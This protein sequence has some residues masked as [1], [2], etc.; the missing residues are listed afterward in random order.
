MFNLPQLTG[1]MHNTFIQQMSQ[2]YE[3]EISLPQKPWKC[4]W[5]QLLFKRKLIT[6][7]LLTAILFVTLPFFFRY[8]EN[9]EG[10]TINDFVLQ[11]VKPHNV[12]IPVFIAIWSMTAL[13]IARSL[14]KPELFLVCI[15]SFLVVTVLRLLAIFLVPLNAPE[16][17]IP[18]VDPLSNVFYGKHFVTKDLFFSG[19]TAS[20][21]LIFLCLD[22]RQD[23]IAALVA[24]LV[25]GICVLV[26]HVHYTFDVIAAPVFTYL[27]Y[28]IG[29][30]LAAPSAI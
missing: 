26:Q 24:T 15:Y 29:K 28:R 9:R 6:A 2:P 27:A 17:L 20:Q 7:L 18:L 3:L 13:I 23:K 22:K 16:G 4:A 19:H 11:S 25:V 30:K 10:Y 8:I 21:F 1:G 14:K 5:N 12:S